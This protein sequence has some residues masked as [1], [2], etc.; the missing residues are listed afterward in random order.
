MP[1]GAR[2]Q[3]GHGIDQHHGRQLAAA[4]HVVADRP[5]LIHVRFDE[6]LVDTFVTTGNEDQRLLIRQFANV[7]LFQLTPLRRQV[8]NL[9]LP[10]RGTLGISQR[11]FER[12]DLHHHAGA[13]AERAVIHRL[14]T[15]LGVAP[16]IPAIQ[17]EQPLPH[18]TTGNPIFADGC[19]H[20]R[21][22]TDDLDAQAGHAVQKSAS[23]STCIS[24]ESRSTF[25]TQ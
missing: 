22:Q 20:I 18:R 12:L 9:R 2:K 24:P 15:V 14:M 16:G 4:Q 13:T 6:A 1:Q 3:P 23:Q 5:F 10:A 25:K 8:D 17:L 7:G 19:E 21:E 11:Q